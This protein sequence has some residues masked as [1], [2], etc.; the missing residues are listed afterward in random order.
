MIFDKR[1]RILG[2]WCICVLFFYS[3]VDAEASSR[4][5]EFA[6]TGDLRRVVAADNSSIDYEYDQA[7]QLVKVTDS[8][9]KT[10]CYHYDVSGNCVQAENENGIIDY[11]YDLLNH[12]VAVAYPGISPIRYSYDIRGRIQQIIYPN[13]TKVSYSYDAADRLLSV[14]SLCGKTCYIYDQKNNTLLKTISPTGVTT[15]YGY[16]NAK[17]VTSVFHR[18]SDKT[19]IIGFQYIFDG[20]GNRIRVEEIDEK[21]VREVDFFYDKLNR[22]IGVR[23][24]EFL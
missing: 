16:D 9:G 5:F 12:L 1:Y 8:Q 20:N 2:L 11:E 4:F 14:E 3:Q 13:A 22:L 17:R 10:F 24:P 19:L 15:E 18:R 6:E 23:Y 7:H 21:G